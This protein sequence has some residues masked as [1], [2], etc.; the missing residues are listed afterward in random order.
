MTEGTTP[1]SLALCFGLHLRLDQR[2]QRL[3]IQ[4]LPGGAFG[5]VGGVAGVMLSS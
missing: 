2:L 3:L 1:E 4:Q 5:G